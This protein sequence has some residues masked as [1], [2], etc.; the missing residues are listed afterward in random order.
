MSPRR[1]TSFSL[2][3]F[4]N[5]FPTTFPFFPQ[6]RLGSPCPPFFSLRLAQVK[7]YPDKGRG[8]MRF[9]LRSLVR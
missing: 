1:R 7:P 5:F 6:P 3:L 2:F 9:F 8:F 4:S